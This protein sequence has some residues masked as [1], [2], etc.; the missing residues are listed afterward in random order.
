MSQSLL[1]GLRGVQ[2]GGVLKTQLDRK[3]ITV[4]RRENVTGTE[5]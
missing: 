1:V 3:L 2:G 5:S 4:A